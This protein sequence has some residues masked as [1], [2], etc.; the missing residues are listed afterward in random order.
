VRITIFNTPVVTVI[1]RWVLIFIVRAFG[2]HQPPPLPNLKKCVL[3]VAPHTSNWDFPIGITYALWY[4]IRVNW[5]GKDSLFVPLLSPIFRWMGGIPVDRSKSTNMVSD[6]ARLFEQEESLWLA[7]APEGT[8]RKVERW[9]T[10]FY[11]IAIKANVP[12]VLAYIDYSRKVTAIDRVIYP[13]G[14]VEKELSAIQA[15]YADITGK[16]PD[17]WGQGS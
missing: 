12:I 4:G 5:M 10:G 15:F 13:T 9:K 8:R 6:V 7:I 3:V 16:N 17:Q 14:D 1:M 11:H 2:W